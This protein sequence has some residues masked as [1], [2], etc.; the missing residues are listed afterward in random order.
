MTDHSTYEHPLMGRYASEKMKGLFSDDMRFGTWILIWIEIARAEMELGISAIIPDQI[1]DM[2]DHID[3]IDYELANKEE[4]KRR[5]DVMAHVYVYGEAA[6]SAAGIIHLGCTSCEI[7]DNAELIV[8]RQGLEDISKKIARVIWRLVDFAQ[9]YKMLPTLGYTHY[10]PA[11]PTTVG[12]RACIWINDLLIDLKNVERCMREMRFRGI[13]G[14]VGT[15]ASF[16]ELFHG[17]H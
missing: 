7:T 2:E 4:K 17:D 6:K 15:Q 12:K 3:N 8:M 14:T 5:H 10:Q 11:Q 13:Q 1:K 16:L 9:K